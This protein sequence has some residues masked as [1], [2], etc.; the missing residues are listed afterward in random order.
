MSKYPERLAP[1]RYVL[2][3]RGENEMRLGVCPTPRSLTALWELLHSLY[4]LYPSAM[5]ID[6]LCAG[7]PAGE[8]VDAQEVMVSSRRNLDSSKTGLAFSP[9][10]FYWYKH[11]DL[12]AIE[13]D[14]EAR[15][16]AADGTTVLAPGVLVADTIEA[17]REVQR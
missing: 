4:V 2:V 17:R 16:A 14:I 10:L 7:W 3:V 12:C 5:T 1:Q 13:A 9:G 11:R 8:S 15:R 6:V